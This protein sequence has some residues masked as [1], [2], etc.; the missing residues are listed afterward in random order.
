M[1]DG[2]ELQRSLK[3]WL[4]TNLTSFLT[5]VRDELTE[6]V[7]WQMP[8]VEDYV[9]VIGVKDFK[10]GGNAVFAITDA[11]AATYRIQGLLQA[12]MD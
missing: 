3:H 7:E 10:D 11:N 8:I 1:S 2:D 9:L 4:E 12:A 5:K 6:E